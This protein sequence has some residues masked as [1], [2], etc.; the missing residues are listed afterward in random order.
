MTW[1]VAALSPV[2]TDR[3]GSAAVEFALVAPVLCLMLVG[4]LD[5]AHQAYLRAVV[6][7]SLDDA[8]RRATV[9]NPGFTASGSTAEARVQ[10]TIA[11]Q[12]R[13]IAPRATITVTQSNFYQFTGIGNPEKLMTDTGHDGQFDAGEGD[14][15]ED[16]NR[17][18][19]YDANAGR[20][21]V[22]GANDAVFYK[23]RVTMPRLFPVSAMLGQS[24]TLVIQAQTAVRNQPYADQ[25]VPPV[26]CGNAT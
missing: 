18:G 5:L 25:Q 22:G 17:N 19:E 26:L 9:Q 20:S 13:A 6:Q 12:L 16:L 7:G 14:C 3:T 21:G 10:A 11:R 4:G 23:V 2:A 8:S 24:R 15:W 1:P